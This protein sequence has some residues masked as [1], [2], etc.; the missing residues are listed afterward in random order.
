MQLCDIEACQEPYSPDIEVQRFCR[1]C[2]VW[3]HEDCLRMDGKELVAADRETRLQQAKQE[4][5][6]ARVLKGALSPVIRG[7]D[8]VSGEIASICGTFYDSQE[9]DEADE[10][11]DPSDGEPTEWHGVAMYACPG[12]PGRFV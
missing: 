3:Y 1:W 7:L 11:L 10:H 6:A 2:R 12:C 4:L 8:E 5:G 9:H